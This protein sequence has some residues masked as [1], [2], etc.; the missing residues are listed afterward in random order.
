MAEEVLALLNLPPNVVLEHVVPNLHGRDL[1]NIE[2][3]SKSASEI[4][5][6]DSCWARVCEGQRYE[7]SGTRT[8]GRQAWRA[9]YLIRACANCCQPGVYQLNTFT[10]GI[11]TNSVFSLCERCFLRTSELPGLESRLCNDNFLLQ[12]MLARIAAAR[13]TIFE[14]QQATVAKRINK[15]RKRAAEATEGEEDGF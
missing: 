9:I 4:L 1:I 11:R 5:S 8:R 14:E 13:R 3:V 15:R 2:L 6:N 7:Q 12:T 10:S